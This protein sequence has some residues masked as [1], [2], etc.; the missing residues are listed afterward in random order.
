MEQ[1]IKSGIDLWIGNVNDSFQELWNGIATVVP[2]LVVAILILIVGW[3]VGVFVGRVVSHLIKTLKVDEALKQAGVE[4]IVHRA[5]MTLNSGYFFGALIKWFIIVAFLVSTLNF[6][7]LEGVN[8]FILKDLLFYIPQIIIA[9]LVIFLAALIADVLNKL[10]VASS[11][12]VSMES[13]ELLGGVIKWSIWIFAIFVALDHL[14]IIPEAFI[15]IILQGFV[16][17]FSLAFGLSFGLGGQKF[18]SDYIEKF[19]NKSKNN[20]ES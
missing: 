10:V 12:A 14:R 18:A 15:Q 4:D 1:D 3:V 16:I 19:K 7:G 11:K 17:A 5:G 20:R 2:N 6:L 9:T 8:D 13:A